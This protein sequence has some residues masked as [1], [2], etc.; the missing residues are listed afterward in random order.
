MNQSNSKGTFLHNMRQSVLVTLVLLVLCGL[1]FPVALSGLSALI[2]PSQ[3]KGSLVEV[4]GEAVGA[5]Y[6]G[7]EFTED[8]FMKGRPSAYHYNTYYED[9]EGNR[10]Y[11]D[12]SE[13]AGLA[14]G[15][16]NYAPSNPAL[17]ERVEADMAAFLEANPTVARVDIPADLMTASGS[18][19][20][21]HI[22]PEAAAIQ[23]PALAE[24]S[25]LSEETLEQIVAD[26]TT[27]KLL[28]VFGEETVN[29]L[30]VNLEI[31]QAM[32]LIEAE[33]Q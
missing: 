26:N 8:Y 24:A 20:D 14:S 23:I 29:V 2:F 30:G 25:G 18:G 21:P 12:G 22:S 16:S 11:S 1:V 7:Q 6:V 17:A 5:K 9:A 15:S 10:Y 3:A 27:G 32:G 33:A 28:G 19:L 4:N 31:A 13:F